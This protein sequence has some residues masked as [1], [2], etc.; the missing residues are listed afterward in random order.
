M[1]ERIDDYIRANRA[2][3]TREAIRAQL[4]SAGHDAAAV[5]SALD[6]SGGES[7]HVPSMTGWRP[8]WREF[9]VLLVV[10]IIGAVAVWADQP[11]GSAVIAPVVYA[12]IVTVGF[13]IAKWFSILVDTGGSLIPIIVLGVIAIVAGV[14]TVI[15]SAPLLFGAILALSGVPALLLLYMRATNPRGAGMVGAALPILVWLGITGTC[16]TPL[17]NRL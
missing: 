3:Y 6:R 10:G 5:D 15:S 1:D 2:K 14:S 17:L 8:R 7:A 12:V 16:Y 13:G 4:I 9:L 11:Y